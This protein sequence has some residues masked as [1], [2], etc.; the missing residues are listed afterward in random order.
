V[1]A[2]VTALG[3]LVGYGI[4]TST[5]NVAFAAV[6]QS[7]VRDRLRGRVF[8]AFDLFWQSMRLASPLLGGLLA[9]TAGI[10]AVYYLCGLLL[11]ATLAGLILR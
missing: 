1:L 8:S 10:R 9:D 5:G 11:A 7:H 3:T 6:I 2:T 4:G